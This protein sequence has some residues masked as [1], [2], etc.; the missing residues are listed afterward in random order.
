MAQAFTRQH[1]RFLNGPPE[2]V[3]KAVDLPL[4]HHVNKARNNT[5]AMG[6]LIAIES[7]VLR[8]EM[9][10]DFERQQSRVLSAVPY[11]RYSRNVDHGGWFV[12]RSDPERPVSL[13]FT[14]A[15]QDALRPEAHEIARQL[16]IDLEAKR[17][18]Q[19]AT[20]KDED[21]KKKEEFEKAIRE[22]LDMRLAERER[23]LSSL[24]PR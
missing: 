16:M 1:L 21:N 14:E 24:F 2:P 22:R 15:V 11:S 3:V 8:Y 6:M 19:E 17:R 12:D 7:N 10:S 13:L 18:I 23:E 20:Q 9:A 4:E 5:A